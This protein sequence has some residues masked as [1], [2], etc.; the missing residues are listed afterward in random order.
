MARFCVNKK[1]QWDS[2]DHE[3]HD[4]DRAVSC[5]PEEENRVSLGIHAT[6]QGAVAKARAL[7]YATA[8]GCAYCAP[9]CH[10]S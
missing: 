9:A 6:C 7:G 4:L 10:N 8:D 3:V 1:P 5:L 2:R